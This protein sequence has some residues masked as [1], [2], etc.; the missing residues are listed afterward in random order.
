MRHNSEQKW[1]KEGRIEETMHEERTWWK[2]DRYI[3]VIIHLKACQRFDLHMQQER[4]SWFCLQVCICKNKNKHM[5]ILSVW[6][7]LPHFEA[8]FVS[9]LW[10]F[11]AWTPPWRRTGREDKRAKEGPCL[12][13]PV[14]DSL[15]MLCRVT[16]ANH[17]NPLKPP[18]NVI[19]RTGPRPLSAHIMRPR[20]KHLHR[21]KRRTKFSFVLRS[22]INKMSLFC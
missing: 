9:T 17:N 11:H 13:A 19:Q 21:E 14:N 22:W 4:V 5:H 2:S 7:L 20:D 16:S 6:V 8:M 1:K 18:E 10:G 15:Q 3:R 12:T